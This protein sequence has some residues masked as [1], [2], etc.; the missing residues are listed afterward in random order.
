MSRELGSQ[1][2]LVKAVVR[3]N[4]VERGRALTQPRRM[5]KDD[6]FRFFRTSREI[7]R[8]AVMLCLCFPLSP[9]NRDDLLHECS[10]SSRASFKKT[11]P[12][13]SPSGASLVRHEGQISCPGRDQFESV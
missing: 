9:R 10:L 2:S 4:P 8:L 7:I 6:P 1:R 12:S 3:G 13:L 11:G 5:R